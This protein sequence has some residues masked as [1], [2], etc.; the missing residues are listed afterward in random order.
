MESEGEER[1]LHVVVVGGGVGRGAGGEAAQWTRCGLSWLLAAA[2]PHVTGDP[3]TDPDEAAA[4]VDTV[5][6]TNGS[7]TVIGWPGRSHAER[8][9]SV[10]TAT[11]HHL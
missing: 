10:S 9:S 3:T 7:A 8:R 1:L 2:L 6:G 5:Q 11:A 4:A